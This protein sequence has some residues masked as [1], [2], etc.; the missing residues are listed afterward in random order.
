MTDLKSHWENIYSKKNFE[1]TSWF[2]EKP[3]TSINIIQSLGLSKEAPIIDIGGGNS[4]LVDNLLDL[5]YS[6]LSVLDISE[7]AIK[8]AK[9]RLGE[10]AEDVEWIVNDVTANQFSSEYEVWHDRAAFHFLT[11]E[12]KV[13][14][15]ISNLK[16]SLRSGGYLILGTF[17]ENGPDKCSG[18]E[19]KKY[20][21]EQME[22]L[23]EK[24]FEIVR[25]E[26]LDHKTPWDAVQNFTFGLFRRK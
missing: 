26:N 9:S 6:K 7:T 10:K 23:F 14:D 3:E 5:G 16:T 25:L 20:S 24:D 17:S 4:Y 11:D 21:S 22:K 8:K 18:I 13:K 12:D 19:I 15:Y 2:Q 1:E